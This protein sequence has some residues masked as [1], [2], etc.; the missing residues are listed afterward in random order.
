MLFEEKTHC[1]LV[2]VLGTQSFPSLPLGTSTLG[3]SP[4]LRR[5]RPRLHRRPEPGS[6]E[7]ICWMIQAK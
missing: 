4:A 6:P 3:P 1:I 5:S 2:N 7:W